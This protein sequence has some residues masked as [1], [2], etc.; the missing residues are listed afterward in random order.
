VA[1]SAGSACHTGNEHVVSPV[2]EAMG[3][4][5]EFALGTLRLCVGRATTAEEVDRAVEH[6]RVAVKEVIASQ[7]TIIV[8]T[9]SG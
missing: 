1:C 9:Q 5:P 4:S 7:A 8:D 2:L 3:V 6:I